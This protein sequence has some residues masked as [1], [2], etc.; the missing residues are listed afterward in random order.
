MALLDGAARRPAALV[1]VAA[2]A[3]GTLLPVDTNPVPGW[4]HVTKV[5]PEPARRL[6]LLY[7][8][9]LRHTDA[10]AV[11]VPDAAGDLPVEHLAG[12]P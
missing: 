8:L 1:D 7:P 6:P 4:S 5:D 3:T 9:Y 10:V 11:G 12:Q 2:V